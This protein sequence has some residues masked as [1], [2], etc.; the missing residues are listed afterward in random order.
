L[1]GCGKVWDFGGKWEEKGKKEG[2]AGKLRGRA[3]ESQKHDHLLREKNGG[4][5]SW[6][7]KLGFLG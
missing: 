1:A 5:Q 3:I 6:S 4:N 2:M 7:R